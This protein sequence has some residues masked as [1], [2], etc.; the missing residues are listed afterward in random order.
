MAKG[1]KRVSL[2][3]TNELTVSAWYER[4]ALVLMNHYNATPEEKEQ[5]CRDAT[6]TCI[7]GLLDEDTHLSESLSREPRAKPQSIDRHYLAV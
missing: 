5:R 1:E 6:Q 2:L 4:L 3:P 7:D